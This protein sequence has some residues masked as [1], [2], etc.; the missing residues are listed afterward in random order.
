MDNDNVLKDLFLM[1]QVYATLFSVYNKLQTESDKHFVALSSRQYMTMLAIFHLPENETTI[2]N[3]A[4]KLGS[5]KQNTKQLITALE[6]KGYIKLK[7]SD[8]D[9]RAINISV[10]PSGINE[11]LKSGEIGIMFLADVFNEFT[12]EELQTLWDLMKKIY[13]FDGKEQDGF[14]D[15][16]GENNTM[17]EAA[18]ETQAKALQAF[19]DK[20]KKSVLERR[21]KT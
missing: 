12:G 5:T 20:R 10:T 9:K 15:D 3:I 16:P 14:E 19:I 21:D 8:I 17:D 2:N 13:R 4:K 6:K 11:M 7:P 18:Q 1:Q